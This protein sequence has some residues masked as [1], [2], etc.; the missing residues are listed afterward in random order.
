MEGCNL[1]RSG[2]RRPAQGGLRLR[3]P[4]RRGAQRTRLGPGLCQGS[5]GFGQ[6]P[7]NGRIQG[8]DRECQLPAALGQLRL[9]RG[10]FRGQPVAIALDP[11]RLGS[12]GRRLEIDRREGRPGDFVR[13]AAL[14]LRRGM[15]RQ[16][17][18]RRGGAVLALLERLERRRSRAS[19]A[20]EPFSR[21][22]RT[23]G[24]VVP[25]GTERGDQRRRQ[26]IARARPRRLLLG[27]GGQAA[28]LRTQ[29]GEDVL[30][31]GQVRGR[32]LE[33]RL[34]AAAAALVATDSGYL[35]E[36][37]AAL[38]RSQREGL[39]HHPLADEQECV[40]CEVRRVQELDD[41]LETDP[42]AIDEVVVLPGPEQPA[43][44]LEDGEVHWHQAVRVVEHER[45]VGHAERRPAVGAREDDVLR[46][47]RAQGAALLAE[48]PPERVGQVALSRTVRTDDGI[49]PRYELDGRPF[50]E[51]LEPL[52]AQGLEARG[53]GH[54]IGSGALTGRRAPEDPKGRGR[55]TAPRAGC[56][57]ARRRGS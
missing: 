7:I 54:S 15:G 22:L 17:V 13:S 49:D 52:Q 46:A 47:A 2:G 43:T 31:P 6:L 36:E 34:G 11:G 25:A 35:L 27:L 4:D 18:G 29:L 32:V 51:R 33:L 44:D 10:P 9:G 19:G 37:R 41:I 24:R 50:R 5:I 53:P 30:D 56:R 23:A 38:L 40:V 28:D 20:A 55:P 57:A 1:V 48:G 8:R 21:D 42:L 39:V 3:P 16:L 26:L 45:H 12:G 14:S